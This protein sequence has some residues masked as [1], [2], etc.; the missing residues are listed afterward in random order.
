MTAG[1]RGF[2]VPVMKI[3]T[4][5]ALVAAAIAVAIATTASGTPVSAHSARTL[6]FLSHDSNFKFIDLPPKG[7]E[8]KPP[9]EGDEFVIGGT[10]AQGGKTVGTTNLVC[11]IT[12]PG[13]KGL[14]ACSGIATVPGGTL[15]IQGA[16]YIAGNSDTYAITGG[17]GRYAGA[18][19]TAASTQKGSGDQ[20][21]V[22]LQ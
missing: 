5:A 15:A 12:Q 4:S 3:L 22:R 9:S 8:N 13:A 10:L 11:T 21:T 6:T 7:G 20:I 18:K 2:T 14:S 19:G 1:S 16:S 17:T